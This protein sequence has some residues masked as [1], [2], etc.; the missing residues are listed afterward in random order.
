MIVIISM[1]NKLPASKKIAARAKQR[2]DLFR[3][4]L[5]WFVYVDRYMFNLLPFI[6]PQ[7][8]GH[9]SKG[10]WCLMMSVKMQLINKWMN[11]WN[12]WIHKYDH[13]LM[14]AFRPVQCS[15]RSLSLKQTINTRRNFVG[16]SFQIKLVNW[17]GNLILNMTKGN[18]FVAGIF[19]RSFLKHSVSFPSSSFTG[20]VIFSFQKNI[21]MCYRIQWLQG[22]PDQWFN[23]WSLE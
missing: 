9:I 17:K 6:T 22:R 20:I 14:N 5:M 13:L 12:E 8:S 3:F 19:T 21:Q 10:Q 4:K 2:L 16:N 1:A 23:W 7:R 15:M 11:E 18:I